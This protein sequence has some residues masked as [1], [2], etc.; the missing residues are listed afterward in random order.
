MRAQFAIAL[1]AFSATNVFAQ[2]VPTTV[3]GPIV[4]KEPSSNGGGNQADC[5]PDSAAT[6]LQLVKDPD[7]QRSIN[8]WCTH[9]PSARK[10]CA[11]FVP[12]VWRTVTPVPASW[13]LEDCRNMGQSVGASTLQ[14]GCIF[15]AVPPGQTQKYILGGSSGI[16]NP[17]SNSNV[18]SPN[19]GW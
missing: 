11:P 19:C 15:D 2:V 3:T 8:M 14:A 6:A 12:N 5:P 18:P 10:I 16:S 4:T 9:K 1:L 17:P 7:G 13:T